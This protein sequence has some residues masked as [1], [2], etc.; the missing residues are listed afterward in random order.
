VPAVR[1]D[2]VELGK[3]AP[4]NASALP[5][6]PLRICAGRDVGVSFAV[7]HAGALAARV[8]D[9]STV[10]GRLD[11]WRRVAVLLRKG[12]AARLAV[13]EPA[14]D[15][16]PAE[17]QIRERGFYVRGR[18]R[19]VE[20]IGCAARARRCWQLFEKPATFWSISPLLARTPRKGTAWR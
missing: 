12:N 10:T 19:V 20:R 14:T 18:F 9:G 13:L 17:T 16:D 7:K 8:S 2:A 5:G 4:M 11:T 1:R 15:D 3:A 6:T